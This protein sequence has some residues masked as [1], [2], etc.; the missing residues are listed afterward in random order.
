MTGDRVELTGAG[1]VL[2]DVT[3][4][5]TASLTFASGDGHGAVLITTASTGPIE[6]VLTPDQLGHLRDRAAE[7]CAN[8]RLTAAYALPEDDASLPRVP[9]FTAPRAPYLPS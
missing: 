6:I 9:R 4:A 1:L 2:R 8:A 7:T 5:V 3:G